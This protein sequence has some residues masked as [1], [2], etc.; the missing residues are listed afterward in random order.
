MK[1]TRLFMNTRFALLLTLAT[2]LPGC[3]LAPEYMRPDLE[4]PATWAETT[5]NA[6]EIQWWKRF[7]DPV[8]NSLI[9]NTIN[10]NKDIAIAIA[11]VEQARAS[12][13]LA[14]SQLYPTLGAQ[15]AGGRGYASTDTN[16]TFGLINGLNQA[17]QPITSGASAFPEPSRYGNT[18]TVGVQAMWEIDLFG[19]YRNSRDAAMQQLLATEAAQ[20]GV[21]LSLVSQ[22]AVSYFN[23]RNYDFQLA[24]ARETLVTREEA[25]GIYQARFDEG[26]ISDLDLARA[27]TE[28]E[29]MRANVFRLEYQVA[30]AESALLYLT[31]ASPRAIFEDSIERGKPLDELPSAPQLPPGIPSDLLERRPD[32]IAAEAQL[33]AANFQVGVAKAAWFPSISLT[34][35]LGTQSVEL[36][37]LFRNPATT[38][39]FGA[40]ATVPLLSFGRI[41][42]N[43]R[44][45]EA[46]VQEQLANYG[47]TV[48]QSFREMR[49]ALTAQN[50]LRLVITPLENTVENL[51]RAVELANLRYENGYASYLEVLDAERSLYQAKIELANVRTNHLS[52]IVNVCMALG[53]GWVE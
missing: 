11:R 10:Y 23:L 46:V 13:G 49:D 2:V 16:A 38:W 21:F 41:S 29:S 15:A 8:L 6:L 37:N 9:E 35:L 34:G 44:I 5:P 39:N 48:Q 14:A 43:V 27:K 52:S 30:T 53:G 28:V 17:L 47:K 7:E 4:L 26:L 32:I 42:N 1:Q 20:R 3:S 24:I 51:Q 45:A 33:Q 22:T 12:L 19:K 50:Q 31:G 25:M 40:N 18:W 36:D